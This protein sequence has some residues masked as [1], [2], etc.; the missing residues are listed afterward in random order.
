[1][2]LTKTALI[3]VAL[4]LAHIMIGCASKSHRVTLT[5]FLPE[6]IQLEPSADDRNVLIY[7]DPSFDPTTLV[8]LYV[9]P[10]ST[11]NLKSNLPSDK[12]DPIAQRMTNEIRQA[13]A[14]NLQ[15]LESPA[16]N[17]PT[18]YTALTK[19]DPSAPLLNIHPATKITGMGLGGASLEAMI[20][21]PETQRVLYAIAFSRKAA[22]RVGSGLTKWDDAYTVIQHWAQDLAQQWQPQSESP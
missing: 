7:N 1:M 3:L 20:L 2:H 19:I 4:L 6:S 14:D 13:L 15:I 9:A 10:V 5:G 16:T 22:K 8:T 21:A 11:D 17:A 18:L 12:L